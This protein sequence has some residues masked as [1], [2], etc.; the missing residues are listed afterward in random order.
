M[1]FRVRMPPIAW[2]T[3]RSPILES[4]LALACLSSSR[5]AGMTAARADFSSESLAALA[6]ERIE[7]SDCWEI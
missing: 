4:A 3:V 2:P 6:Y 7:R 1:D 5:F